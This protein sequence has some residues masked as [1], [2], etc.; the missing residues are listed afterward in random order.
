MCDASNYAIGAI[1]V[2]K[3]LSIRIMRLSV[4][5]G[6]ERCKAKTHQMNPESFQMKLFSHC[7]TSFRMSIS[8]PSFNQFLGIPILLTFWP[9]GAIPTH[10][11]MLKKIN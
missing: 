6:E 5:D 1:L 3:L 10:S 11:Q 4:L 2:P 9:R 8:F 7:G